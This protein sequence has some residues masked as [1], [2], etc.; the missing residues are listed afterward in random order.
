MILRELHNLIRPGGV[1]HLAYQIEHLIRRQVVGAPV[2]EIH[3]EHF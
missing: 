2:V 3:A 1:V